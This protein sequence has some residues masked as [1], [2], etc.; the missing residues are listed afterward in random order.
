MKLLKPSPALALFFLSPAIGELLSGSAPPVEFFSPF[1]LTMLVALYGSGAVII[2]ELKIRWNKGLGSVLLLGAA[3]GILEEGLMVASFF[4]PAWI[5]LGALATYG[6]W[7]DVNWVW[8]VN[9]TIYHAVYS[10]TIPI[11]L[12]ELAYPE[13]RNEKWVGNKKL[14]VVFV[15][16][17]SDV[18]FGFFLFALFLRYWPPFPQYLLAILVMTLFGFAAY[19]VPKRLKTDGRRRLPKV[20]VMWA[21]GTVATFIFFFSLYSIHA[22]MP[23]WQIGIFLGPALALFF[24][25]LVSMYDWKEPNQ[26]HKFALAS[27]ALTF[28]IVFAP[29]QE[30]DK[31]RT[32]NP[33]GMSLVG[34]AFLIGLV[35]LGRRVWKSDKTVSEK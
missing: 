13:R 24:G 4:N 31:T 35:L 29:L 19:K 12:V 28:F 14:I 7:L 5:D 30:L 22:L 26:K 23:V 16:L 20:L 15:I 25:K 3:Y 21:I 6:R 10:I 2:R 9:L 18:A 34:L 17:I 8:A 1:G 33:A 32:D 27:G 11:V